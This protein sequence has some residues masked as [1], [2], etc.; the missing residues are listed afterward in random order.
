MI[1]DARAE[2]LR[3]QQL[4]L[5][6]PPPADSEL[7]LAVVEVVDVDDVITRVAAAVRAA[8]NLRHELAYAWPAA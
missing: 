7:P 1:E 2:L 5:I 6:E 8:A 3:P 4:D